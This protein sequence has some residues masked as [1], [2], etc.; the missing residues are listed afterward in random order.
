MSISG[1]DNPI[2]AT[3]SVPAKIRDL[4]PFEL[5]LSVR[6]AGALRRKSIQRLGDLDG[7]TVESLIN[8]G[9]CGRITIQELI[10]LLQRA[11]AGEFNA[12]KK[13]LQAMTRL[14]LL[15]LID[16]LVEQLP[17][18]DRD[19]VVQRLSGPRGRERKLVEIA[20]VYGL[21]RERVRQVVEEALT[22][23]RQTGGPK[24][25]FQLESVLSACE[26]NVY[27]LTADVMAEWAGGV[28]V[29]QGHAF[30]AR[31]LGELEPKIP[32]WP[33]NRGAPERLDRRANLI[34]SLVDDLITPGRASV[35]AKEA[36]A[37]VRRE[38]TVAD[39]AIAEFFWVLWHYPRVLFEFPS[40][41]V[42]TIGRR[43][44][45]TM[46][47]AMHVLERS[48]RALTSAEIV[49]RARGILG[50]SIGPLNRRTLEAGLPNVEGVFLVGPRTF[51]LS[52]HFRTPATLWKTI[53]K[54]VVGLLRKQKSPI[55]TLEIIAE[56]T[57]PWT[58]S[59]NAYELAEILRADKRLRH[60]RRL[61]FALEAS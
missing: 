13:V 17:D 39:V 29:Q 40:P 35:T 16:S 36:L 61:R 9:N 2:S 59:T 48:D 20:D 45:K 31:L 30:Y 56:R 1:S 5:P 32:V 12:P 38:P 22:W 15:H 46:E 51:G 28:R 25:L 27:P 44:F 26:K 53:Q 37:A 42:P 11:A 54:D 7:V 23:L 21:T 43:R 55:S 52:H 41:D 58:E 4:D 24:L 49:D 14:D 10:Q 8:L 18:R 19:I 47:V 50:S 6:L 33:D 3:L 34:A 57:F 60:A